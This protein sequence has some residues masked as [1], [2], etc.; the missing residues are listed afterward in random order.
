MNILIIGCGRLGSRLASVLDAE[1][2][3]I[4]IIDND[5]DR[6]DMLDDEFTG[7][8]VEG[9][10]IDIDV[11]KSAGIEGCDYVVCVT[12][13]DNTNIM[14]AQIA[15]EIFKLDNIICRVLDPVKAHAFESLGIPTICPTSLAFESIC[16]GLFG[17][18]SNSKLVHYGGTSIEF[19]TIPYQ[20]HMKGKLLSELNKKSEEHRLF[21]VI[22]SHNII[23]LYSPSADRVVTETDRL[24]FAHVVL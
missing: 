23:T 8:T 12:E 6:F 2:H 24:I 20:R 19:N 18:K 16:S 9:T 5:K 3:Y 14:A 11:M 15:H 4:A 21:A 17:N 22:D 10:P 7:L 1:G 13:Q